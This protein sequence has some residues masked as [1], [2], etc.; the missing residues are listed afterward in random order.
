MGTWGAALYDD[1]QASDLKNTIALISKVP[2]EGERLLQILEK[3]WGNCDP[4][5]DDGRLFWLVVADQFERRG[6]DC[7]RLPAMALSIIAGGADLES[8]R[9]KGADDKFL[10]ERALALDELRQRLIAPRPIKPRKKAGKAPDA[11]LSTGEVYTFP[12]MNGVAWCPYRLPYDPPFEPNEWGAMVVLASGR[13]FDWLP[14]CALASLTVDPTVKPT[15]ADAAGARLITHLQTNG[16]GIFVPKKAHAT[17]LEL[18]GHIKLDPT[19]VKPHLS[20]FGVDAAIQMDW[21]I[22]YGA[23]SASIKGLPIGCELASLTA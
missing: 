12:A 2:A 14:W 1:D 20:N 4:G 8:A 11:V 19:L 13:A 10:K 6:I 15:L 18:L 3:N 17:G 7:P 21:T 9:D 23:Y 22:A 16:A 5:D